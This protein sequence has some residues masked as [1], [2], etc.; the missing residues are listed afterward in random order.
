M[1]VGVM[2]RSA[3]ADTLPEAPEA[4]DAADADSSADDAN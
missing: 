4:D 2:D 3:D 1:G